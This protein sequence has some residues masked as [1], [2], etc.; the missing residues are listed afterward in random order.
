MAVE[1]AGDRLL[2]PS[3]VLSAGS[4]LDGYGRVNEAVTE[5]GL[6]TGRRALGARFSKNATNNEETGR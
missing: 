2:T 1:R 4:M 5:R 3:F 6:F